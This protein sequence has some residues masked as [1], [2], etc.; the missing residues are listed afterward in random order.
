MNKKGI[1][2]LPLKYLIIVLFASLVI[3]I[4]IEF[5][6]VLKTGVTGAV[7]EIGGLLGEKVSEVSNTN[8]PPEIKWV[9]LN[10]LQLTEDSNSPVQI[11]APVNN[12]LIWVIASDKETDP[13]TYDIKFYNST[14]KLSPDSYCSGTVIS[15][16]SIS[17]SLRY[18]LKSGMVWVSCA[19][20]AVIPRPEG[21]NETWEV[22]VGVKDSLSSTVSK[23]FYFRAVPST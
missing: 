3:G 8:S 2:G 4:V 1:E 15:T 13:I 5:T 6:G 23:L 18:K 9:Y 20:P 17:D 19:N 22:S 14:G 10:D 12:A 11:T 7:T 21:T 16:N